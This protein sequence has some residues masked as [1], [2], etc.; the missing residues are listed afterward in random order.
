MTGKEKESI[1]IAG[2]KTAER[3]S[4]YNVAKTYIEAVENARN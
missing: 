4:D 3:L 2:R 1:S